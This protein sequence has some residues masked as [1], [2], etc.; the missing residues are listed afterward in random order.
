MLPAVLDMKKAARC[1]VSTVFLLITFSILPVILGFLGRTYLV[2]TIPFTM[3]LATG[4]M[5]LALRPS[6][7]LA[8]RMFK[9]SSPYLFV[10]FFAM[11]LDQMPYFTI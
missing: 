2:L 11:M 9:I 1:I 4:N 8:W 10:L 3:V 6:K 7:K 5:W